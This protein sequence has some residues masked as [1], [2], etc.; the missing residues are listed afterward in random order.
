M[1]TTLKT[2]Y[3]TEAQG[4]TCSLAS[5]ANAAAREST[6]VDN[7]SNKYL[8]ALVQVRITLANGGTIGSDK[9]VYVYA[10]G[11]VDTATPVYPDKVT[12]SD[13]NI[14]LD[15]PSQLKVIGVIECAAYVTASVVTFT[16]PPASIAQ[17]FGG[18]LPTK[19]GIVVENR[20]NIAFTSGESDKKKIYQGIWALGE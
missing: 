19:W 3:G 13:A 14:T 1:A 11:T 8:D 5:L 12:G 6:A 4:I 17:A 10:Y 7:S 9:K 20:T 2:S 18:I 15:A 16:M